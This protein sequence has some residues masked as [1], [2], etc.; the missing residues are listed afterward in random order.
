[1]RAANFLPQG[2]WHRP[3]HRCDG[4]MVEMGLLMLVLLLCSLLSILTIS[5]DS[6]SPTVAPEHG[7]STTCPPW[8]VVRRE[9]SCGMLGDFPEK[10]T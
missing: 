1:M 2:R 8:L 10:V 4:E 9:F 3:H 7:P 5:P 6:F